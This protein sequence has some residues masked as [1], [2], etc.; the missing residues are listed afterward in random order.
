MGGGHYFG[1]PVAVL[2][3]PCPIVVLNDCMGNS[4][5]L[6]LSDNMI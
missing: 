2:G 3:M 1:L 4:V 6:C 5:G